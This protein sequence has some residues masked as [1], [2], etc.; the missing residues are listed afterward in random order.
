MTRGNG[1]AVFPGE[2]T[3]ADA[4]RRRQRFGFALAGLVSAGFSVI[5]LLMAFWPVVLSRPVIAG[6]AMTHGLFWG[7]LFAL[8]TIVAMGLYVRHRTTLDQAPDRQ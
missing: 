3:A 4:I 7:L 6:H 8:L 1:G 5:V 2:S